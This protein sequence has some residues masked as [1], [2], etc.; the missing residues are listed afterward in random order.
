[1]AAV[2]INSIGLTLFFWL[3]V[4]LERSFTYFDSISTGKELFKHFP[5]LGQLIYMKWDF[6][7]SLPGPNDTMSFTL[8]PVHWLIILLAFLVK[9][10]GFFHWGFLVFVFL[11]LPVSAW[12]WRLFPML[13]FVQFPWRLV[14]FLTL[15]GSF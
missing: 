12:F 9:K 10:R 13:N 11:A 14:L 8:G 15:F 4:L 7:T 6:G 1:M 5:T 2:F 3:P